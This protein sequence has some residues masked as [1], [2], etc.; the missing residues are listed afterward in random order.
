MPPRA[1]QYD[2]EIAAP[3]APMAGAILTGSQTLLTVTLQYNLGSKA[4]P[5]TVEVNSI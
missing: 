2:H 3:A 1:R 4:M 5:A